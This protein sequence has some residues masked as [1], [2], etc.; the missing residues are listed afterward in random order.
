MPRLAASSVTHRGLSP[1][2][3]RCVQLL[4]TREHRFIHFAKLGLADVE[5]SAASC[6]VFSGNTRLVVLVASLGRHTWLNHKV[7]DPVPLNGL[8]M[9]A[10]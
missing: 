6:R 8:L 9:S 4:S 7:V 10:D 2:I 3:Q 5:L 1:A